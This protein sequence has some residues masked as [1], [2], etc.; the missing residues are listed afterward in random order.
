MISRSG[1]NS[2]THVPDV[3]L[4]RRRQDSSTA[5]ASRDACKACRRTET[6]CAA[7]SARRAVPV[8]SRSEARRNSAES[9]TAKSAPEAATS[10]EAATPAEAT[11]AVC[12]LRE[13]V[14]AD[15]ENRTLELEA[16]VHGCAPR[17]GQQC[18]REG[19]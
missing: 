6:S 9:A 12:A 2:A 19:V 11:G 17:D 18:S 10:H 5:W 16:V 3:D 8:R 14:L 15:F 7:E 13:A 4:L 1:Q